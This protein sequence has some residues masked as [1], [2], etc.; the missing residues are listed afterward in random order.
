MGIVP[1]I[2]NAWEPKTPGFF[3]C[4]SYP[5]LNNDGHL[6]QAPP[7]KTVQV[8]ETRVSGWIAGTSP[9]VT[10]FRLFFF[11]N[12]MFLFFFF[13]LIFLIFFWYSLYL[14]WWP[15]SRWPWLWWP[16]PRWTRPWWLQP[17][18]PT[19]WWPAPWCTRPWWP[20][21]TM[22][23]ST[24]ESMVTPPMVISTMVPTTM[25]WFN[26][27]VFSLYCIVFS[28]CRLWMFFF[29]H[30]SINQQTRWF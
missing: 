23:T 11:L 22:V 28:L 27:L 4:P 21:W 15:Q 13:I 25:V 8:C 29:R 19:P 16:P 6:D 3:P 10:F 26:T 30:E 24:M 7:K 12:Y 9:L 1:G 20:W 17:W 18:W 2:M 14:F 5:V